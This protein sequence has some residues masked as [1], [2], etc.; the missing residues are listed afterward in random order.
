MFK[1]PRADRVGSWCS[2]KSKAGSFTPT[3]Y[4]QG[5]TRSGLRRLAIRANNCRTITDLSLENASPYARHNFVTWTSIATTVVCVQEI[6]KK[7]MNTSNRFL[8]F[9]D[10]PVAC[11][12]LRQFGP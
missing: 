10:I 2:K 3:S 1:W 7:H 12:N 9:Y 8:D 4:L 5:S 11:A 6:D